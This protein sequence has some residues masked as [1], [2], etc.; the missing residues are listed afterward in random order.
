VKVLEELEE[1]ETK[2]K[3]WLEAKSKLNPEASRK[4]NPNLIDNIP[5]DTHVVHDKEIEID[6]FSTTFETI[7]VDSSEKDREF[8]IKLPFLEDQKISKLN[9][10][11]K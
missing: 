4:E 11:N 6:A 5:E 9:K 7:V 1:L 10:Y 2:E 8:R 3:L